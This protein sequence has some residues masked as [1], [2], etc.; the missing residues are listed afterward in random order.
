MNTQQKVTI[1]EIKEAYKVLLGREPTED[2]EI[3]FHLSANSQSEMITNIL[4][5]K[6]ARNRIA[7]PAQSPFFFYNSYLDVRSLVEDN[8]D[9]NR[10]PVPGHN[11][12]FLGVAV[13]VE[14][15]PFL[16]NTAGK[17][18]NVPIP[19][20][21]HADMA[22]WAAAIRAVDLADDTFTMV[23]LGCGWGCWM[24]NTGVLAK[25]RGKHINLIGVEGDPMHM[26]LCHKTMSS[27]NIDSSEYTIVRG[28]AAGTSGTALFPMRQENEENWGFK[29]IFNATK[30]QQRE[31]KDSYETLEML[32]LG[33]IIA[34]HKFVDLLHLDIQGGEG[35]LI[36]TTIDTISSKVGYILVGT[37]SRVLE[38]EIIAL[39][40]AHGWK[41]EIERPAI[42]AVGESGKLDTTV[43]GVQAWRNPKFHP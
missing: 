18:D 3:N 36:R 33:R 8:V 39:L 42:F 23:E 35:P 38:G 27:N 24:V 14:V 9:E 40:D 41:L 22:E 1:L 11:V 13:P 16:A 25:R 30:K 19:A 4:G 34:N 21:Y 7:L 2:S 37:H 15:F 29:P 6:E 28:V 43:D 12:N 26:D 10:K 17:L 31:L 20:N 5:S 32:P